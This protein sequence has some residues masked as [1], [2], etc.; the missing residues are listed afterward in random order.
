[1]KKLHSAGYV[2][3]DI[4]PQNVLFNFP[5]DEKETFAS[6][7]YYQS[8]YTLIDFGICTRYVDEFGHHL[9]KSKIQKF[10]GSIEFCAADVL[11]QY[12]PTR[13]HDIES[14]LYM[15]MHL[16]KNKK[17]LWKQTYEEDSDSF[18]NQGLTLREKL[19]KMSE[20]KLLVDSDY[21]CQGLRNAQ[22]LSNFYDYV[23]N[24]GYYEEPNYE[25]LVEM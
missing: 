16:L 10:R 20:L 15:M 25:K 21:M 5:E 14:L 12:L 9:E 18:S 13:K 24:I 6:E 7:S 2:H 11:A 22:D 17:S 23:M 4:K 19:S 8:N 1:L 3:C